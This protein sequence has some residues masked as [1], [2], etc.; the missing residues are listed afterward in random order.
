MG[1]LHRKYVNCTEPIVGDR[2]AGDNLC[3]LIW[4]TVPM[5]NIIFDHAF[6]G[7]FES[8]VPRTASFYLLEQKDVTPF[9]SQQARN[10]ETEAP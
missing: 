2:K 5:P 4:S 8:Y 9:V 3:S 6:F 1:C 7:D 10:W